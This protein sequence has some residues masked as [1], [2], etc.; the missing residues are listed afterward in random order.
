MVLV[1]HKHSNICV[2]RKF[3]CLLIINQD[4]F[5]LAEIRYVIGGATWLVR[6]R[7]N[8]RETESKLKDTGGANFK[9]SH[10]FRHQTLLEVQ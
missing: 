6:D 7:E 5:V 3:R 1:M 8:D 4:T 2:F 9:K 10:S